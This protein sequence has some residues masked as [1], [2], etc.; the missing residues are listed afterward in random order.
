[1]GAAFRRTDTRTNLSLAVLRR[2]PIIRCAASD[3]PTNFGDNNLKRA[4]RIDTCPVQ[5]QGWK[6]LLLCGDNNVRV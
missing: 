5:R 1:M 4:R 6:A 3:L 2:Q